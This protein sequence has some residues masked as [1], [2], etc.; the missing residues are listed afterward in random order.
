MEEDPSSILRSLFPPCDVQL[1]LVRTFSL[2]LLC[3]TVTLAGCQFGDALW[4]SSLFSVV[5]P[6]ES[7][8]TFENTIDES[9]KYNLF[10]FYYLY[11]GGG[12]SVGDVSGNGHPDLYFTGNMVS[13]RL[14]V[15]QGNLQ[16]E[17]VTDEAGVGTEG[18][19]TGTTFVDINHDG[20]LDIYVCRAGKKETPSE[21]RANLL[22]VNNGDGTF[23]EKASDYGIADTSYSTQA[24]FFDY[25]QDGDLDLYLLTHSMKI[26]QPNRLRPLTTDGSGKANDRLYENQGDGTFLDVTKEAGIVYPGMGLGVAI[27][28]VNGNGLE[29]VY[30]ANDFLANDY[31]Y[32]NQGDGTFVERGDQAMEHHSLSSMGVALADVNNDLAV[33]AVVLDMLAPDNRTRKTMANPMTY[34]YFQEAL[35]VGYHP[36]YAR[37]TLQV[38]NGRRR[39][40][41]LSFSEIGQQ[42]GID[43]TGWSWAP[44]V[45]DFDNDGLRDLWVTN[46]YRRN[47]VDRDLIKRHARLRQKV[48]KEEAY[49]RVQE[50][51]KE[52]PSL[53]RADFVY[54]NQGDLQ[55]ADRRGEWTPDREGYSNGGV[56][57]DLDGDGD[58][59]IVVNHVNEPARIYENQ[60]ENDN[61][62]NVRLDGPA[63]NPNGLG[64]RLYLTCN[65]R[66]QMRHQ[67]MT[68]GYQSSV[69]PRLHFGLGDC[70]TIDSLRV[71]WPDSATQRLTDL[72]AN[73]P[74]RLR[75]DEASATES[76]PK[77]VPTVTDSALLAPVAETRNLRYEHTEVPYNDFQRQPLLPH[78]LSQLGPGVAVGDVNGDGREDAYVGGATENPGRLLVQTD[79]DTFR[80]TEI[81]SMPKPEED[82]GV[83]FFDADGDGDQDLYVASGSNEYFSGSRHYQ[84]RLYLNDS[85][86]TFQEATDT[87]PR[88][89]TPSSTVTAADYD[90]DGDLDLFVGGRLDPLSES[91][92]TGYPKPGRSYVIEN[93]SGT[94]EDVTESVAPGLKDIGM[95]TS[96]LWTDFNGDGWTDLIVAGEFMPIT[97]YKNEE[98]SLTDVT[99]QTG[100]PDTRG[101]WNSISGA[102]FDRDGHTEYVVGNLGLNSRYH[103]SPDEPISVYARDLNGDGRLDPFLTFYLNGKEYPVHGLDAAVEQVPR[104]KGTYSTYESYAKETFHEIIPERFVTEEKA[105]VLRAT[106][107]ESSYIENEGDG[108][109]SI[110]P[111]PDKTQRAPL[112][113]MVTTDVTHNGQ[114]DV[115][116]VGNS[117]APHVGT[118]RLDAS[119]GLVLEGNGEGHFTPVPHTESGLFLNGDGMGLA[120]LLEANGEPLYLATQNKD[121]LRAFAG[122][123]APVKTVRITTRPLDAYAH[124]T[125]QEGA[126]EKR[127]LYYGSGYLSQSSRAIRVPA[128]T[129]SVTVYQYD[130]RSR[131][132]YPSSVSSASHS[133]AE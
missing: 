101:W 5:P 29:D 55:F 81:D 91:Q 26:D 62:L 66:T 59:D 83:L 120:Q 126:T 132:I 92:P 36:Q 46:G 58:L 84:D 111:L 127:E 117:Y 93:D 116:A 68:R 69:D 85:T 103:A 13:S 2:S 1:F 88:M 11:N 129:D 130:G 98:G 115:V 53:K 102:D 51:V 30:V 78:K 113:G 90:R 22:F 16:F 124:I 107:L 32:I 123:E 60:V 24:A 73:E 49:R 50:E 12:V 72:P 96:A 35:R 6:G 41:Q 71:V 44:L 10:S 67:S 33:D 17:D 133:T 25:D 131:S 89:R 19:A 74:V 99:D 4:S 104:M 80:S 75:Y 77:T 43:A 112:Y 65:G 27:N 125:Y 56:Y 63:K 18:W 106:H 52:I 105:T 54:Q 87:L 3:A 57:S 42:A 38:N 122:S 23:T 39:N 108:T 76:G 47:V 31:L 61:A 118:G 15:N 79:A 28:D 45:A 20:H 109:F 40:G 64:T 48:G 110:R 95:V 86:G 82:T 7:G 8:V 37:N 119:V 21:Q 94:F 100:L 97:F 114:L 128:S 14:Y 9:E 121:S 70:T 34:G